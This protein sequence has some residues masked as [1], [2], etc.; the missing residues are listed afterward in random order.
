[1]QLQEHKDSRLSLARLVNMAS[2]E[3]KSLN[4][5]RIHFGQL[6]QDI[7]PNPISS[8][9]SGKIRTIST[10]GDFFGLQ[11]RKEIVFPKRDEWSCDVRKWSLKRGKSIEPSTTN[12]VE[13]HRF[14]KVISG[15]S[16][17]NDIETKLFPQSF[18]ESI[19]YIA[20]GSFDI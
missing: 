14:S 12:N 7:V 13:K 5:T 19:A 16:G 15:V 1:M 4:N 17:H 11:K 9:T 18:E 2:E 20:K 3:T 6:W 8:E 10:E